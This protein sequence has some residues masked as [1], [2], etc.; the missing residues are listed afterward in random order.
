MTIGRSVRLAAAAST[1]AFSVWWHAA[2]QGAASYGCPMHPDL[3]SAA[4]GR[5]A[6]CGMELILMG[7]PGSSPYRVSV[8]TIPREA[9]P[10]KPVRIRFSITHPTT[11]ERVKELRIVHEMP[12][13][14]FVVS[15]DL[16]FYDHIHP[17]PDADGA[18][19]VDTELPRAGEYHLFCDFLPIGGVPQVIHKRLATAG[20]ARSRSKPPL[21]LTADAVLTKVVDG[22]RFELTLEPRRVAAGKTAS[23]RYHLVD[24]RTGA[25]VTDLEPYLGAW[26]HTLILSDDAERFLHC[27]PTQ[28]IPPDADR[29][30]L[31]GGPDL[32]FDATVRK[33]GMHRL[34]SQFKRGGKVTTVSF[35]IDVAALAHLAVWSGG[36]WSEPLG[37]PSQAPSGTVRALASR[38]DELFAGGD[39]VLAGG[40]TVNGIARW[41]G[42][43]WRALGGG[44]DGA[45]H[46]IAVEG[47]EVYFGGEFTAAGGRAANGIARW[48]GR[49]FSPLG[50][51]LSGSRDSVR[52]SAVFAIAVRGREVYVGGRF[53]TAGGVSANGIARWDGTRFTS[54]GSGVASGD[55]AGVVSAMTFFRGELYVAGQFLTAGGADARNIA[56]WDGRSWSAVGGG[57]A[58]GLEKVTA[59]AVSGDRLFVGGDF[60]TAGEIAASRIASWD[61][62]QWRPLPVDPAEGVRAIAAAGSEIYVA[63]GSFTTADGVKTNGIVKCDR[64]ACSALGAGLGSGAVLAPVL[65]IAPAGRTVYVGGGPFILR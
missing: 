42:R 34:W 65:A 51:G 52:P 7:P 62:T 25:P 41:D 36:A 33:P 53:A 56:R 44:V 28:T 27:H 15:D 32:S 38:G 22:I 47:S 39:F 16:G 13:H 10:G 46:A 17:Q 12:F 11:G 35:T 24:D 23:L 58:G 63:G 18:F 2:G 50:P 37:G 30:R 40:E 55:D 64:S 29:S 5:C 14:L 57:V 9:E 20:F 21:R 54:L 3:R 43:R 59:L 8:D 49:A 60:T 61:G 48:D 6:V 4:P 31:V 1:L 26:G 45:V 19:V